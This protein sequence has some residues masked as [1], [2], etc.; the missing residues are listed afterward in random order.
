MTRTHSSRYEDPEEYNIH[1]ATSRE[2]C[3]EMGQLNNWQLVDV[4]PSGVEIL[5]VDCIFSG[6]Q[7]SFAT[8]KDNE[9]E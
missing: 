8:G 9:Y 5:K 4:E 2:Q 6:K 1:S 3:L 7:T